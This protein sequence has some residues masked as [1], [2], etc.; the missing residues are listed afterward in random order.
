[1]RGRPFG[2]PIQ[3]IIMSNEYG[4]LPRFAIEQSSE[5]AIMLQHSSKPM[6]T[7]YVKPDLRGQGVLGYNRK[8]IFPFIQ[9]ITCS[10]IDSTGNRDFDSGFPRRLY[11]KLIQIK[12]RSG[13]EKFIRDYP[14]FC[15]FPTL[16]DVHQLIKEYQ[17]AGLKH[18]PVSLAR[19]NVSI[20]N[21]RDHEKPAEQE[22]IALKVNTDFLWKKVLELQQFVNQ[23]VSGKMTEEYLERI[24]VELQNTSPLIIPYDGWPWVGI[25]EEKTSQT[26]IDGLGKARSLKPIRGFRVYGHFALCCLEF[27]HDM[28]T[29]SNIF[30]CERCGA[31]RVRKQNGKRRFCSE[32]E[33]KTCYKKRLS[34]YQTRR[35]KKKK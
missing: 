14:D 27:L 32:R 21:G 4:L 19:I 18:F 7:V 30:K 15:A 29:G 31:V 6:Q 12:T 5:L 3:L 11:T 26:R 10:Y 8:Q 16:E 2:Q 13:F 33:S 17:Q 23:W 20:E 25:R 24:N 1:M 34:S 9:K 35:V 28:E 22:P